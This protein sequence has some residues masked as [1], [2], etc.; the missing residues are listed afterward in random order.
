MGDGDGFGDDMG[1]G[2]EMPA[3]VEKG[4]MHM[5]EEGYSTVQQ[6]LFLLVILGVV[7][8]FVRVSGWRAGGGSGDV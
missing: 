2:Y 7:V 6:G 5:A 8:G 1:S 3:Y 4:D